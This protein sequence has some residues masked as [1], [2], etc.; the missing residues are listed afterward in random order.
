MSKNGWSFTDWLANLKLME[1]ILVD[2]S[3]DRLGELQENPAVIFVQSKTV[4]TAEKQWILAYSHFQVRTSKFVG[5]S[6]QSAWLCLA[7]LE[8]AYPH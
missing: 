3:R 6:V 7:R 5:N 4:Y 8:K 2:R 1:D